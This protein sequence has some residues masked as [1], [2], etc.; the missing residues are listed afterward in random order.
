MPVYENEQIDLWTGE[1]M[2]QLLEELE[3]LFRSLEVYI[4]DREW[5]E[6]LSDEKS[7]EFC[8]RKGLVR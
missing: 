5:L 7:L 8:T 6:E 3:E 4:N 2:E 1:E